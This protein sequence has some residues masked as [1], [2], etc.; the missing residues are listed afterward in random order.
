MSCRSEWEQHV[1][2][3]QNRKLESEIEAA[4]PKNRKREA[5]RAR[6]LERA[7]R[8]VSAAIPL[9]RRPPK[10][11]LEMYPLLVRILREADYQALLKASRK[12]KP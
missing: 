12:A 5:V 6:G 2:E 3:E 1:W 11:L 10:E 8:L 9:G 7:G 4:M